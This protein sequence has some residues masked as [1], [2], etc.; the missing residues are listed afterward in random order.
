MTGY[1]AA[2]TVIS[3][4]TKKKQTIIAEKMTL[5]LSSDKDLEGAM[6]GVP[7]RRACCS[8]SMLLGILSKGNVRR[9]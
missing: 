6:G 5:N 9:A 1:I 4:A 2:T 7:S 3:K 8:S